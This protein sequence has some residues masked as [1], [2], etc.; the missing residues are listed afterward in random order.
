MTHTYRHILALHDT[1]IDSQALR[2]RSAGCP[3]DTW[4]V[5]LLE[6]IVGRKLANLSCTG[7][8]GLHGTPY[9]GH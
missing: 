7:R 2:L 5:A 4:P 8:P 6:S 9:L 3:T 1:D